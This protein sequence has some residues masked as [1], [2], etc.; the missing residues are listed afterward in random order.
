ML[1]AEAPALRPEIASIFY[2]PSLNECVKGDA[3]QETNIQFF[4]LVIKGCHVTCL[5]YY[6]LVLCRVVMSL[7]TVNGCQTCNLA[8]TGH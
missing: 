1:L 5:F 8:M 2:S 6:L 3:V 4:R 7:C